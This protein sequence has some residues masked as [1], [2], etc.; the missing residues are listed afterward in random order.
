MVEV[1]A[2]LKNGFEKHIGTYSKFDFMPDCKEKT[3]EKIKKEELELFGNEIVSI[4]IF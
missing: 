3:I 1:N 2:I 4:K